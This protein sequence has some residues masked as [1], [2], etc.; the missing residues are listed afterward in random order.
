MAITKY[1]VDDYEEMVRLG[2]LTE[3]DR[4]ELIRGEIVP[5]MSIGPQR[6]LNDS[7]GCSIVN[8]ASRRSLAA[9][10]LFGLPIASRSP[11]FRSSVLPWGV[12]LLVILS[13][14]ISSSSKSP[15]HLLTTIET[16]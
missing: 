6:A 13:P 11:I 7:F 15:A 10:I 2:V 14:S 5:K 12:T 9:R 8:L 1:S 3:K 4:V 16:S